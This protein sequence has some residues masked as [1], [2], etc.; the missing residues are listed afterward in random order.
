MV[1]S[2]ENY[3]F[4][5]GVKGL[6][7]IMVKRTLTKKIAIRSSISHSKYQKRKKK[8]LFS[9]INLNQFQKS[10]ETQV[11]IGHMYPLS[12]VPFSKTFSVPPNSRH[13]TAL[14]MYSCP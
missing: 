14:L 10:T 1:D 13:N 5:L 4:D 2:K 8:P 3:K 9:T 7:L 12:L 11:G 6:K